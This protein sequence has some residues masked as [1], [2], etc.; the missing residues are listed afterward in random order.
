MKIGTHNGPFHTDEVFAVAFLF[1]L[2]SGIDITI[3]RSRDPKVLEDCDIVVDVGGEH[4]RHRCRY[5]HHQTGGAGE[6]PDGTKLSSFGLVWQDFRYQIGFNLGLSDKTLDRIER[7]LVIPIDARDNGQKPEARSRD[8]PSVADFIDSLNSAWN[9]QATE[10]ASFA[11]AVA[12]AK[13]YLERMITRCQAE[14]V[15]T[16]AVETA[17]MIAE[18]PQLIILDRGMPWQGTVITKAPKA[19]LVMLPGAPGSGEWMVQAIPLELGK[20]QPFRLQLPKSWGGLRD[21]QL[22]EVTGVPD[23]KFAHNA[24][25]IAI[26][27]SKEGAL[28]LAKLALNHH[29]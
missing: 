14:A 19:K 21:T 13:R 6:W 16:E 25:Y 9:E 10:D 1:V 29:D 5:D 17:I 27:R 18:N 24:G 20:Q 3:V 4:E 23:A 15:A 2:F 28:A 8:I 11:E 7:Q 22:A 26:A 12:F